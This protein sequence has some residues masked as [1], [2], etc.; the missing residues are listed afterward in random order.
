MELEVTGRVSERFVKR[1]RDH[2]VTLIELRE[3]TT[4]RLMVSYRDTVLLS[5][6]S[7]GEKK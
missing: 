2:V 3:A 4:G 7:K 1:G 6:V 5:F